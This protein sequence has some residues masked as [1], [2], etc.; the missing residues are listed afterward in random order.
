MSFFL[1]VFLV[2]ICSQTA[3]AAEHGES[4]PHHPYFYQ[5]EI[6]G[7]TSYLLGTLHSRRLSLESFHPFL[8][9]AL[10]QAKYLFI[11]SDGLSNRPP[12]EGVEEEASF[13][14]KL[15]R[16]SW[17]GR[18]PDK[19]STA[20]LNLIRNTTGD[21]SS[22]YEVRSYLAKLELGAAYTVIRETVQTEAFEILRRELQG[23]PPLKKEAPSRT[24]DAQLMEFAEER[25]V[26]VAV[27]DSSFLFYELDMKA[28]DQTELHS[29]L[30]YSLLEDGG[31]RSQFLDDLR[32]SLKVSKV[33][34]SE[35]ISYEEGSFTRST[36]T[37]VSDY[38]QKWNRA[39]L[40]RHQQWVPAILRTIKKA[41]VFVAV[42][43]AH[44]QRISE[45]EDYEDIPRLLELLKSHGVKVTKVD[46]SFVRARQ[47]TALS[48]GQCKG[49]L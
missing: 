40:N 38:I 43:L 34:K 28:V 36:T 42:G 5:L 1:K 13:F 6:D 2:L 20:Y 24:F 32:E 11:E 37:G 35:L 3:H 19:L 44:V 4:L 31:I 48:P 17:R 46:E 39:A 12:Q 23:E 15:G 25:N 21:E 41:S 29:F 27:L 47:P 7:Q 45:G 9:R 8:Q 49:F 22:Y 16:A 18:L 26:K 30:R 14:Y 33:K 10:E